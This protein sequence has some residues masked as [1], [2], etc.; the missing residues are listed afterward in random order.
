MLKGYLMVLAGAHRFGT[1][2][3]MVSL[4][5]VLKQVDPQKRV[6]LERY[7][8]CTTSDDVEAAQEAII[9][10]LEQAYEDARRTGMRTRLSIHSH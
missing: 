10:E 2:I 3:S 9:R 7:K 5:S 8:C 6:Y 4:A 1:S